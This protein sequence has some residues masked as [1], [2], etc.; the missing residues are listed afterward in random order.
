M[1]ACRKVLVVGLAVLVGAVPA[2][3]ERQLLETPIQQVTVPL[4]QGQELS[5]RELIKVDGEGPITAVIGAVL[6]G[7][8][9]YGSQ[10]LKGE[11]INLG[12]IALAAAYGAVTLGIGVPDSYVIKIA[13]SAVRWTARAVAAAGSAAMSLGRRIAYGFNHYIG[14]PIVRFFTRLWRH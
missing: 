8:Y 2:L 14:G 7:A 10:R 12:A 5:D 3:A 9:E 13:T 4:P 6:G 1:A 11:K